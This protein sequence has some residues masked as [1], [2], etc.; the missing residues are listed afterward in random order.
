M[1]TMD[2]IAE[3]DISLTLYEHGD[4]SCLAR[5]VLNT[6]ANT[7]TAEGLARRNPH[8]RPVP[9][10]GDE[11]AAGRALVELGTRLLMAASDDIAAANKTTA[12]V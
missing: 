1:T 3:W 11:L 4:D 7:L 2:H 6:G 5:V 9:E 10:I 8:D 12:P